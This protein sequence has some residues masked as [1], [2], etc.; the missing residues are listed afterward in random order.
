MQPQVIRRRNGTTTNVVVLTTIEQHIAFVKEELLQAIIDASAHAHSHVFANMK[1]GGP[2]IRANIFMRII[3]S[4]LDSAKI[5]F[6]WKVHLQSSDKLYLTLGDFKFAVSLTTNVLKKFEVSVRESCLD[7]LKKPKEY[8][9]DAFIV[10]QTNNFEKDQKAAF[11]VIKYDDV[12]DAW[13]NNSNLVTIDTRGVRITY[14]LN[15][16]NIRPIYYEAPKPEDYQNSEAHRHIEIETVI[17]SMMN[18][19]VDMAKK[20]R[21]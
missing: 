4:H 15:D 12:Y 3:K 21:K 5:P 20:Q 19:V 7:D 14:K 18:I 16:Y 11:T 1:T 8:A 10:A 2:A 9:V 13:K 6:S 17:N